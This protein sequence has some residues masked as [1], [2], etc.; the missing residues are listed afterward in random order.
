MIV[1]ACLNGRHGCN[2]H[3]RV[4]TTPDAIVADAAESVRAG[5][6]ELHIHVRAADGAETLRPDVVDE[7]ISGLRKACP[8]TLIGISTGVWIERDDARRRD[9]LR[10]LSVLPDYASVNVNEDDSAGLIALL[11]ERGIGVELGIWVAEDARRAIEHD[12]VRPCFRV[13]LEIMH[14]DGA[15]ALAELDAIERVL[16]DSPQKSVLLHGD[17]AQVWPL[18]DAAFARGYSTR[19]GLEDGRHLPDG[20]LA[21]SNAALVKAAIARRMRLG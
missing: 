7:T 6:N 8:G 15:A 19:V 12:L 17:K 21:T 4:P 9:Y 5:A 16:A 10:R 14:Q 3:P 18:V 1:Q 20:T 11:V 13:L 2:W